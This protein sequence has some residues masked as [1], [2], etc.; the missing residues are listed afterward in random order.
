L[1]EIAPFLNKWL[2]VVGERKSNDCAVAMEVELDE[3]SE[4]WSAVAAG[5]GLIWVNKILPFV[6]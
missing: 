2:L 3:N 4:R 6:A 1:R 5:F